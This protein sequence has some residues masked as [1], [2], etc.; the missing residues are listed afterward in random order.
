MKKKLYIAYGSN[1]NKAQMTYRCPDAKP[2]TA[3]NLEHW[4]LAFRGGDNTAVATIE[5]EPDAMVPVGIWEISKQ[6]EEALDRYEGWPTLYKKVTFT[7]PINGKRRRAMVYLLNKGHEPNLPS[8]HYF[9]TICQGYA[10]FG[11]DEN[12]LIEAV[13]RAV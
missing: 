6:D 11:L 13:G 4:Q 10:D 7:V 2:L 12:T 5:P 9:K 1:L 3:L 8:K